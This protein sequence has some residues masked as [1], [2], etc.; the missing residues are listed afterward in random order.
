MHSV[1]ALNC[2]LVSYFC[3]SIIWFQIASAVYSKNS[4]ARQM[5]IDIVKVDARIF[6]SSEVFYAE[7]PDCF[8]KHGDNIFYEN[9]STCTEP[10]A[11]GCYCVKRD[12]SYVNKAVCGKSCVGR[13]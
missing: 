13:Q 6:L 5:A 12:S 7:A 2:L 4:D 8:A 1:I 3:I 9:W 10:A 11:I